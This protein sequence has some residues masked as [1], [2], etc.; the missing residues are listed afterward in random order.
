MD[1]S[2]GAI[3]IYVSLSP[4]PRLLLE[5]SQSMYLHSASPD[6]SRR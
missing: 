6:K 3:G 4:V 5:S 1:G 2:D